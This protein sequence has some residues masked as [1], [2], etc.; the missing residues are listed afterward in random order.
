MS[1]KAIPE[2]R[3]ALT[4]QTAPKPSLLRLVLSPDAQ[5]VADFK[6]RL[7]G[8][9]LY[10]S[11]H[12]QRLEKAVRS[13]KLKKQAAR[14]FGVD[15]ASITLPAT[16]ADDIAARLKERMLSILGMERGAGRIFLGA[17]SVEKAAMG[18]KIAVFLNASDGAGNSAKFIARAQAAG[19]PVITLFSRA[20]LSLAMGR[21]NVVHAALAQRGG[22]QTLLNLAQTYEDFMGAAPPEQPKRNRAD[23]ETN[24]EGSETK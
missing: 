8:R 23:R 4:G 10:V 7:P 18:G 19:L 6:Q 2:R 9:G 20:E 5:L 13:S 11:Y 17:D 16:F 1:A 3:C 12:R 14:H 22:W 24:E 15:A 21:E